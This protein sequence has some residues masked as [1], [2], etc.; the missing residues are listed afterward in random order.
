LQEPLEP[1]QKR[2]V[3]E[4]LVPRIDDL[5]SLF[6]DGRVDDGLKRPVSPDSHRNQVVDAFMLELERA[7][8]IDIRAY[9]LGLVST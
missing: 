3:R 7:P 8:V 1:L 2:F 5:S 4:M 9:V 6:E